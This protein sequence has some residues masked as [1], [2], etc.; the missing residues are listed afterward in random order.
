MKKIYALITEKA[1][2]VLPDKITEEAIPIEFAFNNTNVPFM[3]YGLPKNIKK[4]IEKNTKNI[5]PKIKTKHKERAI[6]QSLP[7]GSIIDITSTK[8]KISYWFKY[9]CY[10]MTLEEA[11]I[12]KKLFNSKYMP[13]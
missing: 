9:G 2:L 4:Y 5:F 8:E 6:V 12:Y 10:L 7:I 1:V 13:N 11:E 3:T